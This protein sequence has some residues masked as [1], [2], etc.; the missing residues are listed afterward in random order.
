M[1]WGKNMQNDDLGK[2][3][4]RLTLGILMLFHGVAKMSAGVG[5]IQGM[6]SSA[7]LPELLA[8]GV[9]LGEVVGPLLVMAGYQ[10]R[11]GA[12]LII[13]NM[14]FA[15]GLG[16]MDEIL[17]LTSHGGWKIE[18]QAFFLFN[19]VALLFLGPGRY[20]LKK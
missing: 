2:L 12:G 3:I 6:L 11:I 13:I 15:I 8:Y 20:V 14:L 1:D 7:G 9:F 19:A 16:H 17:A 10:L 18:L 4:L 5:G